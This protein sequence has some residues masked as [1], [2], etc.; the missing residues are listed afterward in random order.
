M[1]GGGGRPS[2]HPHP[3]LAQRL[4][5]LNLADR[6]DFARGPTL[7][8]RIHSSQ[9]MDSE[10]IESILSMQWRSLYQGNPYIE[11]HYYQ[12]FVFKHYGRRN[13][14]TFA[15]ESVRELA[16]TE[17][18]APDQVAFVKLEGLGRVAF[19]NIRRP[20]PLMDVSPEDL[21][22]AAA[23]ALQ[24]ADAQD[25]ASH[26][27]GTTPAADAAASL[28]PGSGSG[29]QPTRRLGQEPMLAARIM[30]ED[31]MA[32]ILDVQDI[33]R[34]FVAGTGGRIEN[35]AALLQRR[36]LL[37]DGL[38]ASLRLPEH[39]VASARKE[40][41]APSDGVFLR[42]LTLPKGKTLAA[43]AL[44]QLYPPSEIMDRSG[45]S[46][47]E[48]NLRILWAVLRNARALFG[49]A[50]MPAVAGGKAAIE[51]ALG[52]ASKVAE[53]ASDVIKRLHSP[54]AVCDALSAVTHGDLIPSSEALENDPELVLLPL[55]APGDSSSE[56][57]Y[58]WLSDVLRA[59]L[60]RGA[61]FELSSGAKNNVQ[62]GE[63]AVESWLEQFPK[64]YGV[65]S[66]H[67]LALS[68]AAV[69]AK[70]EG[71]RDGV[72]ELKRMVP[73]GLVRSFLPHCGKEQGDELRSAL[74]S[75]GL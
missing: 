11:D 63:Q 21:R 7:R 54:Q 27:N 70:E 68:G 17:K 3:T 2:G 29:A 47:M 9:Y 67:V 37:M 75:M 33:D 45:T 59:L 40:A 55:F 71:D 41:G 10:E 6:P 15:P 25:T 43:R 19:S 65:V 57:R 46:K 20:R 51:A 31:C 39:A 18:M 14:R 32:L 30:L 72:E 44:Q 56:T 73:V 49:G 1:G 50:P 74:T 36:T 16:P 4:R 62:G 61:E 22:A 60:Q 24:E 28:H 34:I 69:A 42:L 48:P 52:T 13:R 8:R 66:G 26:G 64:L 58:R 12:A 35:E 5:A 38:A 23:A 53:A